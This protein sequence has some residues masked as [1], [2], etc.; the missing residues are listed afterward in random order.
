M[1][2]LNENAFVMVNLK[3]ALS[4]LLIFCIYV[5]PKLFIDSKSGFLS[6]G[7]DNLILVFLSGK[8]TR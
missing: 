5:L 7:F 6:I 1:S 3:E 8:K 4:D 2:A